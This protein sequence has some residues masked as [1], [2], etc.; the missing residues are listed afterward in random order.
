MESDKR[1]FDQLDSFRCSGKRP[2]DLD[3][4]N[5]GFDPSDIALNFLNPFNLSFAGLLLRY[6]FLYV[7]KLTVFTGKRDIECL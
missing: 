3:I 2:V 1:L 4:G 7:L 5:I 6:F